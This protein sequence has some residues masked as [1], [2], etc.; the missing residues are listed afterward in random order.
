MQWHSIE[1]PCENNIPFSPPASSSSATAQLYYRC[2]DAP[3]KRAQGKRPAGVSIYQFTQ[4][5][6]DGGV[7]AHAETDQTRCELAFASAKDSH[8]Q[9]L[10]PPA[11]FRA[12][13]ARLAN[14]RGIRRHALAEEMLA[15]LRQPKEERRLYEEKTTSVRSAHAASLVSDVAE[16]P[17]PSPP[18]PPAP[19]SQAVSIDE[20]S[21][22]FDLGS[23]TAGHE[24]TC[25][26]E[27][28][29]IIAN[30]ANSPSNSEANGSTAGSGSPSFADQIRNMAAAAALRRRPSPLTVVQPES[31]AG[32]GDDQSQVGLSAAPRQPWPEVEVLSSPSPEEQAE[33]N[34]FAGQIRAKAA[35]LQRRAAAKAE[36]MGLVVVDDGLKTDAA[37]NSASPT[38][39]TGA[40]ASPPS[41]PPPASSTLPLPVQMPPLTQLPPPPLFLPPPQLSPLTQLPPPPAHLLLSP[42]PLPSTSATAFNFVG[43]T[44]PERQT[45]STTPK[46]TPT[47]TPAGGVSCVDAPPSWSPDVQQPTVRK[48]TADAN[49]ANTVQRRLHLQAGDDDIRESAHK[50]GSSTKDVAAGHPPL[51]GDVFSRLCNPS[52]YTGTHKYRF[53]HD[54]RG[55][56]LAGRDSVCKGSGSVAPV[57]HGG[58]V[59]DLSS[60][61]NRQPANRRGIP[62][63]AVER[64]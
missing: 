34:S 53:D 29:G 1:S 50:A 38:G 51:S 48:E 2:L 31:D 43:H 13:L 37:P 9:L 39:A 11:G 61:C 24:V 30:S 47:V 28:E 36:V 18:L 60:I 7:F 62:L 54:G 26:V 32:N 52:T 58:Q 10:L 63:T 5:C 22:G 23:A 21:P 20:A 59:L 41:S 16:K 55:R 6:R 56:G 33:D 42:P 4:L 46:A 35:V 12:A 8:R 64:K 45:A 49:N 14:A 25:A 27:P 15:C 57:Y 17:C 19:H 3:A 40:P 44:A